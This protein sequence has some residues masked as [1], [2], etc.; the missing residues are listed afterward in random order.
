[1]KPG[2]KTHVEVV[3]EPRISGLQPD[4]P[5]ELAPDEAAEWNRFWRVSPP[6]WFPREVWPLLV[7]L[8]RHIVHARFL[9][10]GLQEL[11]LS[12]DLT[13]P[14]HIAHLAAV[15]T[16]H[17]REGRA[18][19]MLCEKLRL[20]TQQRIDSVVAAPRQQEQLPEDKPWIM[21]Q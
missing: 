6:D 10:A 17:D 5:V 20:T 12:Q 11:R 3:M 1:M 7:Q 16:M 18:I 9:G 19:G 2:R 8:C 13:N 21:T 15:S 14:K 4:P